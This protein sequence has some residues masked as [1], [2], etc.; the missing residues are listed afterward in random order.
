MG[1]GSKRTTVNED[2]RIINDYA[3]A[4]MDSSVDNSVRNT[5]DN[6]I[7]GEFAGNTGTINVTDGGAIESAHSLALAGM[8]LGE[9]SFNLVDQ[10]FNFALDAIGVNS[11]LVD[12]VVTA[13]DL[14]GERNLAIAMQMS[15]LG[16]AQ[17]QASNELASDLFSASQGL[18]LAQQ[19]DN[20]AALANGYQAS[21]QFVEDFSRSDGNDLAKTNMKTVGFIMGGLVL[22]VLAYKAVK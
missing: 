20:N 5:T 13:V 2:N 15:E 16:F 11:G 9:K 14:Q 18:A 4:Q 22:S 6:S 12:S 17:N 7:T 10:G 1:F 3:N 8:G 21:M 19:Q